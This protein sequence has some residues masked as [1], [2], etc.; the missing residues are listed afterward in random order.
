[1]RVHTYMGAYGHVQSKPTVLWG[2]LASLHLLHRRQSDVPARVRRETDSRAVGYKRDA[3]GKVC[4][5]RHLHESVAYTE[6]FGV[7][8]LD[9]WQ[10]SDVAAVSSVAVEPVDN[11]RAPLPEGLKASPAPL[12]STAPL[13]KRRRRSIPGKGNAALRTSS[14]LIE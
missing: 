1:M 7:A 9:A 4:G 12:P 3:R 13:G 10:S 5:H 2:T 11:G 6:G 8:L 14:G